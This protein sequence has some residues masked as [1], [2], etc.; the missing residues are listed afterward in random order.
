MKRTHNTPSLL[1]LPVATP[2][3]R[4]G[5][6]LVDF[7]RDQIKDYIYA[8]ECGYCKYQDQ[9]KVLAGLRKDLAAALAEF[10]SRKV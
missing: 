8:C 2:K 10:E 7:C 3:E 5:K 4:T 1:T 6:T 9:K